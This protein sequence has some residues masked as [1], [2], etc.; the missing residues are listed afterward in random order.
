MLTLVAQPRKGESPLI[1]CNADDF[2]I[3]RRDDQT[4][5]GRRLALGITKKSGNG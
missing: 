4:F 3:R 5:T 2:T 1:P